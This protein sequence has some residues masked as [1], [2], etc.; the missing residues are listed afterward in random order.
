MVDTPR[1]GSFARLPSPAPG[2][3]PLGVSATKTRPARAPGA[4]QAPDGAH[5]VRIDTA[6]KFG[7][8]LFR[9]KRNLGRNSE[10]PDFFAFLACF[11]A[12]VAARF[13]PRP[14]AP[15]PKKKTVNDEFRLAG[16]IAVESAHGTKIVRAHCGSNEPPLARALPDDNKLW[17]SRL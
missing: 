2:S 7:R 11:G 9:L 12:Q 14:P 8:R 3:A 5:L 16:G 10:N 4:H 13:C 6:I 1:D 17:P 15:P